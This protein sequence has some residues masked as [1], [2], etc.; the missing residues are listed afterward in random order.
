MVCPLVKLYDTSFGDKIF[1]IVLLFSCDGPFVHECSANFRSLFVHF[2][3]FFFQ[4]T[5]NRT[6]FAQNCDFFVILSTSLPF[7]CKIL[8]GATF[9]F[10]PI[11]V[12]FHEYTLNMTSF[13]VTEAINGYF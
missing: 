6:F 8:S 13:N 9:N 10:R 4:I 3:L 1:S 2:L 7:W 5:I 11:L 12:D